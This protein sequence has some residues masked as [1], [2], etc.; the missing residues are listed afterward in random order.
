[1]RKFL[2]PVAALVTVGGV[3][4]AFAVGLAALPTRA[5]DHLD[6]PGL[7]S[8]GGDS[9]LDITDVYAFQSPANPANTVLIMAVNPAAGANST[10]FH[11]KARYEFLIDENGDAKPDTEIEISFGKVKAANVQ[12]VEVEIDGPHRDVEAEGRTGKTIRI[13]GG[14][15]LRA[16]LFDD[17]FFFDLLAFNAG[18]MFCPPSGT[19]GPN[20]GTNFF[21]GLNVSA[22]V[23]EVPST[24]LGPDMIGVWARTVLGGTQIDRMGR[25]AIN[26]VFIPNNPFEPVN[27]E[28]SQK[29][30]FNAGKPV[31]DQAN[32]RAE[33][34][35]SLLALGNNQAAAD[36]LADVLLPDIL[37]IDTSS[38]AGFLNGRAPAN[39]VIDAELNLITGGG[40]TSDCVA[41]DSNF[42][43]TFPYLAPKNN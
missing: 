34:V 9:R 29:N 3:M 12:D 25:P 21:K 8:P 7:T 22:I 40:I 2:N 41:N 28:P 23:L 19:G 11:P 20:S 4:I 31:N 17:P 36:A 38:S 6:A 13:S 42:T 14:G 33:V 18:A 27:T 30:A 1:M 37:T 15:K 35:D 10:T 39:D 24:W 32:F 16:G 5:A 43:N 26:T